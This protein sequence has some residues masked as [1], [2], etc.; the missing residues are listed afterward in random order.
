MRVSN[1]T[2]DAELYT[3]NAYLVRGDWNAM[4]DVNT[5]VDVGRDPGILAKIA[6]IATGVGKTPV[7]QVVLTHCHFD[8]TG[9]LPL[10]KR[11]FSPEVWALSPQEG[12]DRLLTDGQRLR[13]GD[14][15]YEVFHTPGHSNDS[16][17]LYCARDET[18]FA[19]DTPL[20]GLGVDSTYDPA[21]VRALE[22]LVQLR[23]EVIYFG[24]GEAQTESVGARLQHAL[25]ATRLS[26]G[27]SAVVEA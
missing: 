17:C 11:A 12:V 2:A 25:Q 13:M 6:E 3:C 21:F 10:V 24:H 27:V 18:L 4:N 14:R 20:L 15:E 8:H 5:L 16:I 22:R 19:G 9:A 1:L 23:I 26:L 7:E